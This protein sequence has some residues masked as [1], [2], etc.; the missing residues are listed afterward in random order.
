MITV[1]IDLTAGESVQTAARRMVTAV[2]RGADEVTCSFNGIDL[3]ADNSSTVPAIVEEY[4]HRMNEQRRAWLASPEGV[5][6]T[7]AEAARRNRLQSKADEL[8]AQLPALD[9]SNIEALLDWLS[10]MED[11]RSHVGV[12]VDTGQIIYVFRSHGYEPSA[13]C[14]VSFNGT[15]QRDRPLHSLS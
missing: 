4:R 5:R 2:L 13:N 15:N 10:A 14:D 1:A 9:F 12:N 3:V 8:M 6:R 7:H 11:P